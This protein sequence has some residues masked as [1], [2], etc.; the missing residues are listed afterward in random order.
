MFITENTLISLLNVDIQINERVRLG[1]KLDM[2]YVGFT[3]GT[4]RPLLNISFL[5]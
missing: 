1:L 4:N 5:K 3:Y 2:V